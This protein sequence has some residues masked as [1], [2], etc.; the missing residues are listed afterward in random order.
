MSDFLYRLSVYKVFFV[1]SNRVGKEFERAKASLNSQKE[2]LDENFKR[3]SEQCIA[4]KS[5]LNTQLE[6]MQRKLKVSFIYFLLSLLRLMPIL[7]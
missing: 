5:D 7:M 1:E 4:R 2:K 6:D 3:D